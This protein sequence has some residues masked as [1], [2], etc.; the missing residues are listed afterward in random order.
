MVVTQEKPTGNLVD[1]LYESSQLEES[2]FMNELLEQNATNNNLHWSHIPKG[3]LPTPENVLKQVFREYAAESLYLLDM[4]FNMNELN[5]FRRSILSEQREEIKQGWYWYVIELNSQ[6]LSTLQREAR[7]Y[8]ECLEFY[9]DQN[10]NT[11]YFNGAH[12]IRNQLKHIELLAG[13]ISF[14]APPI[15]YCDQG[16]SGILNTF[17][18]IYKSCAYDNKEH[19]SIIISDI[20]HKA[21]MAQNELESLMQE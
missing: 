1:I 12:N 2:V 4:N 11:E 20:P 16:S 3:K 6:N 18:D 7:S 19:G 13:K 10:I 21:E 14:N 15:I 9:Y 17:I 5:Q 8:G